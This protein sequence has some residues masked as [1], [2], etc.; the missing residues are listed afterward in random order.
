LDVD[1]LGR[2]TALKLSESERES[3]DENSRGQ[4]K[5][6]EDLWARVIVD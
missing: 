2:I 4:R 5:E 3:S 6:G 1:A